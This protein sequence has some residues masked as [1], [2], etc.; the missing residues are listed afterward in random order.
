MI[1]Q[2][3]FGA[4]QVILGRSAESLKD[5]PPHL[6]ESN[7]LQMTVA[8]SKGLEFDD[9]FLWDFFNGSQAEWRPL[10]NYVAHLQEV[11]ETDGHKKLQQEP[12]LLRCADHSVSLQGCPLTWCI[13]TTMCISRH[14]KLS[15]IRASALGYLQSSRTG[16]DL[17]CVLLIPLYL[18]VT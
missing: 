8:Q 18:L 15:Y 10:N 6:R 1:P 2:V 12:P 4:H 9:V 13:C 14:S 11:E 17:V 16:Q 7:V 3:E 5:L